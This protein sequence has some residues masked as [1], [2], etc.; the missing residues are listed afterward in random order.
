MFDRDRFVYVAFQIDTNRI[1]SRGLLPNMN[2]LEAWHEAGVILMHMSRVAQGEARSGANSLRSQK[3]LSYVFSITYGDTPDE[4]T[5]LKA[6]EEAIFPGGATTESE[7]N[8]VEL[9]FNAK[10]Y[11][12]ILLTSDGSSKRQ[13][14]GI[15][16]SRAALDLIGVQVMTDGEAV[17]FVRQKISERDLRMRLRAERDGTSLPEWLGAD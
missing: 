4:Q 15:L 11:G 8:D 13:P 16:G 5:D 6:I 9:A 3:A 14:R 7:R 2:Q 10:K 1:N 12:A 17:A